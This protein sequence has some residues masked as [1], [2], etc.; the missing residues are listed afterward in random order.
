ME[1]RRF[2]YDDSINKWLKG[3][4]YAQNKTKTLKKISEKNIL[5]TKFVFLKFDEV[6]NEAKIFHELVVSFHSF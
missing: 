2:I 3:L 5:T 6:T 4:K 1:T